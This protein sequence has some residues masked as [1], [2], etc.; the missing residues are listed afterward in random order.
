MENY[1]KPT[2]RIIELDNEIVVEGSAATDTTIGEGT[3]SMD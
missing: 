3:G 1:E 2:L